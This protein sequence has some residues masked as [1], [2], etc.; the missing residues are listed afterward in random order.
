[1]KINF[2]KRKLIQIAAFGFTNFNLHKFGTGTIY[3]GNWKKFCSPGLNCYSC[4]AAGFSC[5]IGAIQAVLGDVNYNLSFYV[6][7]LLMAFG[8]I[9]GRFI[10][11][12]LCP[13]GLFQEIISLI[14]IKKFRLPSFMKYIK[15]FILLVFV[16]VVPLVLSIKSFVGTPAFC[17]YICPVGILEGAIPLSIADRG[18]REAL[19]GL[20]NIKFLLLIIIMISCIFV[21]RFFCKVICPLGAIYGFFNKFSLMGL[22]FNQSTCIGC[23]RCKKVCPMDVNPA[24]KPDS[25]EC[26]RCG[27]CVNNCPTHSLDLSL[28]RKY[29][30]KA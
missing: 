1:M 15:Y 9:F 20:F 27:K 4:P 30:N 25:M 6:V 12:F 14:P 10:C 7:G 5:P 23:K 21:H 3:A 11:G 22:S 8:I 26:I 2:I 18:I 19:G 13:F 29:I 17:K 24:V 28:Y 16:V